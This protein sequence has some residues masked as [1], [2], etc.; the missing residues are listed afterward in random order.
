MTD[1]IGLANAALYQN[2]SV[3]TLCEG[4]IEG[5]NY[6]N[7]VVPGSI[8]LPPYISVMAELD[9]D[10]IM[11]YNQYIAYLSSKEPN[12]YI[13]TIIRALMAGKE[14]VILLGKDESQMNFVKWFYQYMIESF[15][16]QMQ[17]RDV[18][19]VYNSNFDG[20]ILGYLYAYDLITYGEFFVL[21][22]KGL[23]LPRYVI[24]KLVAEMN[25][26]IPNPSEEAYMN[27]FQAFKER[28][29]ENNN[30]MLIN[31]FSR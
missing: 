27:Y 7:N 1:D 3:V 11:A 2:M 17:T 12:T 26:Y 22:P 23:E 19:F 18:P 24:P 28:I 31:P 4:N 29:K 6:S 25:P 30:Q 20:V 16:I 21:Y 14:V 13:S 5:L 8:L 10:I 15:G 9:D